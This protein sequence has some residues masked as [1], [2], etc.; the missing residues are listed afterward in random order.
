[1]YVCVWMCPLNNILSTRIIV[2]YYHLQL[3]TVPL[4]PTGHLQQVAGK[5]ADDLTVTVFPA[6]SKATVPSLRQAASSVG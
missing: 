2:L 5:E 4:M 6:S 1:M 3:Q